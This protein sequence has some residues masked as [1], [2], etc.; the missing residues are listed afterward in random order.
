[1]TMSETAHSP[2][3]TTQL[4]NGVFKGGGAKGIA[5]AG[6]LRAVRERG[7]WFGSVAGASAG[8][9]TASLLA[10]GMELD[11]LEAAVPEALAA[12]D[13]HWFGRI[14][15]AVAGHATSRYESGGLREWLNQTLARQIG[16]PENQPVT[17]A[18]LHAA[19]GIELYIIAMDLANGLPVLF[20][21]RTTPEV[22]VAGAVASS[23]AIP[24]GFPAGR[25]VFW[26]GDAGAVVHQLVDGGAWANYP[27][28]I[29]DDDSFRT[30]IKGESQARTVWTENDEHGWDAEERRPTV[31]FIL[32]DPEPLE[33]R[34]PVGLVPLGVDVNRRFDQGPTYT[35]PSR[36][37]YLFG[38]LLSSDW[39]RLIIAIALAVWVSLS[40][41]VLPIGFRR[42]STW[43]FD[44]VPE[45]LYPLLLVGLM[46]VVVLAVV[47][48][49]L[50]VTALIMLGRLLADT[51][52]PSLN[53]LMGVPTE[54][55]PWV[56]LGNR[57][58]VLRVPHAGLSTTGFSVDLETRAAAISEAHREVGRQLDDQII[59]NRLEALLA[60]TEPEPSTYTPGQ[61][62]PEKSEL[63]DRFSVLGLGSTLAATSLVGGLGWLATNLAGTDAI[64]AIMLSIV[65]GL[66]VG[67]LGLWY[68][69][70]RAGTTAAARAQHGVTTPKRRF[71]STAH[72]VMAAGVALV[73][74]SVVLS[75]LAMN[76]R[77]DDT[78]TA[79]V[80]EALSRTDS[81]VNDYM[82]APDQSEGPPTVSVASDRHLRLGERVFV[83][84]DPEDPESGELTRTLDDARFPI[85]VVLAI[86][87][88]GVLTS[89]V[90][91]WRWETRNRHLQNLVGSW[92]SGR[93]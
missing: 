47:I 77:A 90:R 36:P 81:D 76:D 93:P 91:R 75:G 87:G 12:V 68:L 6:A 22:E 60:E 70:G 44:V 40:I 21:R 46:S 26:S 17:F 30:W 5:Y 48:T 92:Q 73:V 49:I 41:V 1:M 10:S 53:A 64:E 39:A 88:F 24:A 71:A 61:R 19:T 83:A 4:V 69:G 32:G 84:I 59:S 18:Q 3:A 85:A 67:G 56:G 50:L 20:C 27:S 74:T 54:V 14:V 63:P 13:S 25:G 78:V 43:L 52:L 79:E 42:F 15:K 51:L 72:L 58:I 2:G 66:A 80:V 28:F 45:W 38:A 65:V 8:A 9:I 7:I 11:D 31:G 55:A 33:H 89:G 37:T 35:S 34:Q 62:P 29:F 16:R 23:S 82:V 57:S 86:L